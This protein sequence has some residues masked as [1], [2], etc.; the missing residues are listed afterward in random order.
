MSRVYYKQ[1][2]N[3]SDNNNTQ[4]EKDQIAI[5]D[6]ALSKEYV[7]IEEYKSKLSDEYN[8]KT[9]QLKQE[10][11]RKISMYNARLIAIKKLQ[12]EKNKR[13]G[14]TNTTGTTV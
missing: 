8:K 4:Q 12:L 13:N 9:S 3:E 14:T 2:L 10:Y 11:D 1:R 7:S 6:P 5:T